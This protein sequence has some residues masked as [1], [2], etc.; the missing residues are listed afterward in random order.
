MTMSLFFSRLNYSG[1]FSLLS[2]EMLQALNSLCGLNSACPVCPWLFLWD[3][4]SRQSTPMLARGQGSPAVKF[5]LCMPGYCWLSLS[6]RSSAGWWSTCPPGYPWPFTGKT[7]SRWL[8]PSPYWRTGL[9]LSG[10]KH[11]SLYWTSWD[12]SLPVSP[13]SPCSSKWQHKHFFYQF[14][15]S[16]TL[17]YQSLF[18]Q[19]AVYCPLPSSQD[20]EPHS[21]YSQGD[22]GHYSYCN[23]DLQI[24]TCLFLFFKY[25]VQQITSVH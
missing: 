18:S 2:W 3:T 4:S 11:I 14:L 20:P 19:D 13:A 5:E 24:S 10:C 21:Q 23:P 8:A 25:E 15:L 9:F 12:S 17:R 6:W 7:F 16:R 22:Q 1:S